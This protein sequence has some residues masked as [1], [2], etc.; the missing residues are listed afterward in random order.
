MVEFYD[1][2]QL[3]KG[4]RGM[5]EDKIKIIVVDD[6]QEVNDLI[7][8]YF[9]RRKYEVFAANSAKQALPIIKEQNPQIMILDINLPDM[10]GIELFKA[11]RQFNSTV[12]VIIVSGHDIETNMEREFKDLDIFKF[13]CKPIMLPDLEEVIIKAVKP[14]G[15]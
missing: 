3:T 8:S 5:P 6:E 4:K 15:G 13:M 11:V 10:N 2:L 9:I 14:N 1:I 12:K 7:R